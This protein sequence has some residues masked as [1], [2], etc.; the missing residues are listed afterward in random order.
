MLKMYVRKIDLLFHPRIQKSAQRKARSHSGEEQKR[1]RNLPASCPLISLTGSHLIVGHARPDANKAMDWHALPRPG[2]THHG[3][4]LR[5]DSLLLAQRASASPQPRK[6]RQ[7]PLS[8]APS[9][10]TGGTTVS[11]EDSPPDPIC[12]FFTRVRFALG[13]TICF[14]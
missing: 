3:K 13:L 10:A 6:P 5:S 11:P 4:F 12:G 14:V 2:P 1:C 7:T 8:P 9:T